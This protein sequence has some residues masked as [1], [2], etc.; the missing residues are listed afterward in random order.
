MLKQK[1]SDWNLLLLIVLNLTAILLLISWLWPAT[2]VWWDCFDFSIFDGFNTILKEGE[3]W[4]TFWAITNWRF[5][6]TIQFILVFGI[7]FYWII[8]K[9]KKIAEQKLVEF[10][11]LI[12]LCFLVNFAFKLVLWI[13]DY[14]RLSPT[15]TISNAFKLSKTVTWLMTKDSSDTAFPGDHAFVLMCA[16]V[17][18]W[19]KGGYRLGIVSLILFTPFIFPRLVVGAHWA[20]DILVGSIS[21]GLITIGWYFGT[22]I[23]SKMPL[24]IINK[25]K[26]HFPAI[27][28]F[29]KKN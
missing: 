5:F 11:L 23:Q 26:N 21:M 9:D 12:L 7:A 19:L 13:L 25:M 8:D 4:H 17:F 22:P 24:W 1:K 29:C 14:N 18:Y 28:S 10:L 16:I 20:T 27:D 2:R 3:E 6:D 15:K